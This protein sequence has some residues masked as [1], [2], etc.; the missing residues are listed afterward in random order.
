M[1][2]EQKILYVDLYDNALTEKKGDYVGKVAITGSIRNPEIANRIVTKRSEYRLE[3]IVNIL[4]LA[5]Q[6]KVIALA[7]GKSVVDGVGQLLPNTI[8]SFDG[9]KAPFDKTK[10]K[11]S[12]AFTMG[13]ALRD[14]L[15]KI[16]V[17]T[18]TASTG[19]TV[20]TVLDSMTGEVNGL[21]TPLSNVVISGVNVRV[22]GDDPSNGVFFTKTGGTAQPVRLITHN[23]P[24]QLT[25]LLPELEDGEYTLS[26]TTQYGSSNKLVKEPRTCTFPVLLYV[27]KKPEGGG[28]EEER[29]GEL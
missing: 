8:G 22:A 12:V 19:I 21:I 9:E 26:I 23:N 10:H 16:T 27:G 4:D 6:E 5:D 11:L 17:A 18:R 13:K 25:V 14:A 2:E 20:N 1:A 24:S 15:S 29:P 3:T 28:G 7:E